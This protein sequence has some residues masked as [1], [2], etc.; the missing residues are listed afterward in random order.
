MAHS[1]PLLEQ[2]TQSPLMIDAAAQDLFQASILHLVRHEHAT[3]LMA[4]AVNMNDDEDFWPQSDDWRAAY[5]PYNVKNGILQIPIMGVLLNRF[6]YQF[7]RWATGYAYIEKALKRGLADGMVRGIAFVHDSPGGEVAGNFELVDKIYNAR[8]QKPTKA[9]AADHSYSASYS[10]ASAAD[11]IVV[12]SS[13]GVGSIGVVTA[14]VDYSGALEQAGIKVT[15]IFAGKHKVDGNSYEKLPKDVQNRI[16]QRIDR[17]YGVFTA[18]VARNR[19][20]DEKAIRATEALTYDAKDAIEVGLAD[21][22][23]A[24]DEEMIIFANEIET[25]DE[26]M[27]NDA[28][29]KGIP[30]AQ[31]E[32]AVAA[33][34]TAGKAEGLKEGAVAAKTRINA[35]LALDESKKRPKAALSAALKT[36]MTVDESKAFLAD[37]PEEQAETKTDAKDRNHFDEAMGDGKVKIKAGDGDGGDDPSDPAKASASILGD[38]A[39]A[40]GLTVVRNKPA[41]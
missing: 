3:A 12:N 2:I 20:M 26:N 4:S 1:A 19:A 23:G 34:T 5:R 27:A 22:I 28:T 14:H 8:G 24:L 15:F 40:G 21:K 17:I 11:Q 41:A 25:G 10:L 30:Q 16:Q 38:Y 31:H 36:E 35:I 7:G 37:I 6:P 29:D 32:S 9:F 39:K 33:A 13:G 18:S